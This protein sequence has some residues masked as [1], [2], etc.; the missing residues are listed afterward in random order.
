MTS[1]YADLGPNLRYQ[2]NAHVAHLSCSDILDEV[3]VRF[4]D[5]FSSSEQRQGG[6]AVSTFGIFLQSAAHN[7][8]A[9]SADQVQ[10]PAKKSFISKPRSRNSPNILPLAKLIVALNFRQSRTSFR[11]P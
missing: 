4:G 5:L 7:A 2:G 6:D 3:T 9:I 11:Y 1:K 8:I 10:P